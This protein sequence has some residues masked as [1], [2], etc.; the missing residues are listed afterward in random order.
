MHTCEK[1]TAAG[2]EARL[3]AV[4]VSRGCTHTVCVLIVT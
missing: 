3:K 1:A 2:W 4:V